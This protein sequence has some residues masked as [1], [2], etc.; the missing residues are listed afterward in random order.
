MPSQ[1]KRCKFILK[2]NEYCNKQFRSNQK[3]KVFCNFHE[4][5]PMSTRKSKKSKKMKNITNKIEENL[6]QNK[7]LLRNLK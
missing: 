6:K 2:N 3:T 1:V 7:K 4:A 5:K